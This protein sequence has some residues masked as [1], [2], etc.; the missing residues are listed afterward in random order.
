MLALGW[1]Q[2]NIHSAPPSLSLPPPSK[3]VLPRGC[4]T[5]GYATLDFWIPMNHTPTV[6]SCCHGTVGSLQATMRGST[7]WLLSLWHK[8]P[9]P[10]L[11]CQEIRRFDAPNVC[12]TKRVCWHLSP[13][14]SCCIRITCA[15]RIIWLLLCTLHNSI[16]KPVL[17]QGWWIILKDYWA[18]LAFAFYEL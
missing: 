12:E 1:L 14:E 16:T 4:H 13:L 6:L 8:A 18:G 2:D 5:P 10:C 11:A 3:C 15:D 17:P 9:G 7:G